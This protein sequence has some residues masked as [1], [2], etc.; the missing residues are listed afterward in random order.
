L[1]MEYSFFRGEM[2]KKCCCI[3]RHYNENFKF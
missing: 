3:S 1:D 2:P